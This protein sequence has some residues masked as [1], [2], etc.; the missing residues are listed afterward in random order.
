M[1]PWG[2]VWAS[3][4]I[5]L[6]LDWT[7][8]TVSVQCAVRGS[9][10]EDRRCSGDLATLGRGVTVLALAPN[11]STRLDAPR[12]ATGQRSDQRHYR[13]PVVRGPP[14]FECSQDQPENVS[15][16]GAL[17]RTRLSSRKRTIPLQHR[18]CRAIKEVVAHG[19]LR[20]R[21]DRGC[22][23]TCHRRTGSRQGS[24]HPRR[25]TWLSVPLHVSRRRQDSDS[26][27]VVRGTPR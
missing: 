25:A 20:E 27:T 15:G 17:Y 23:A 5:H 16:D 9:S 24:Y 10:K 13:L 6:W 8:G 11:S 3:W 2:R 1:Q 18:G 21:V 7:W 26:P 12:P 22:Q 14:T 4:L 19:V